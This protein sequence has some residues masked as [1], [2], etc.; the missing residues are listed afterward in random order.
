MAWTFSYPQ[1]WFTYGPKTKEDNVIKAMLT[2]GAT[3]V[4]LTFSFGTPE[5]QIERAKQIRRI[6]K[7]LGNSVCV[8]ADLQGEKCR[9]AQITGMDELYIQRGRR[10]LLTSGAAYP[11]KKIPE[12]PIQFPEHLKNFEQGDIVIEGDG[13]MTFTVIKRTSRGV[14]CIATTDGVMHPG[15]GIIIQKKSFQ[16]KAMTAKDHADMQVIVKARVFDAVAVSFVAEMDDIAT[17]KSAMKSHGD[18]LPIVAKIET[19]RGIQNI[20]SIVDL[21]DCVLAARG[22]LALTT[23]WIDLPAQV[24]AIAHAASKA[25]KPWILATQLMEGLERFTIPTRAEIC[26]VA[27]WMQAG[28]FGAMLSSETA[29]GSRPVEAVRATAA[30]VHRYKQNRY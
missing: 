14:L 4:R 29:F 25:N 21:S 18:V 28:A 3:G 5:L 13:A 15:R 2:A 22:D 9:L 23:P 26:D 1:I 12:L 19:R 16:P 27:H 17:A 11:R 10:I 20:D 6:A 24:E 8:V 30:L 7:E